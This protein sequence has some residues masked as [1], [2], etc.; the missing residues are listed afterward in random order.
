MADDGATIRLDAELT[1]RL[2]AA[3]EAAG[4]VFDDFVRHALEAIAADD[5]DWQEVAR[6]CQ[7]TEERGD[8]IPWEEFRS[9]L[10]SFGKPR[11]KS[12]A[13]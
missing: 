2:A 7:E 9:R 10:D 8:G 4:E 6:I 11:D 12:A 3:A 13:E 1:Q 5:T